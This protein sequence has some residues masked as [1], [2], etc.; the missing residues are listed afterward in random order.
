MA[1]KLM[2]TEGQEA[3]VLASAIA[4]MTT[5]QMTTPDGDALTEAQAAK[6]AEIRQAG[7]KVEITKCQRCGKTLVRD[8][9]VEREEGDLC[10][11]YY[12]ELGM[13][14]DDLATER[15]KRT[16][17]EVPQGWIKTRQLHRICES[18]S[19][20]VSRMVKAM[21]TDRGMGPLLDPRFEFKYVGNARYVDGWCASEEGLALLK[22]SN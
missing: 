11:H 13:T 8:L 17:K 18:H 12:D 7:G 16:I 21:G 22:A 9:C 6:V 19:I 15:A 2:K 1:K 5:P 20:P 10:S 4:Q 14:K 3:D